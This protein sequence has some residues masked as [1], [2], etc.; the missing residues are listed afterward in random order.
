MWQASKFDVIYRVFTVD[1]IK[2]ST[3]FITVMFS[4]TYFLFFTKTSRHFTQ[5]LTV[6]RQYLFQITYFIEKKSSLTE[7]SRFKRK[8]PFCT[9]ILS[10]LIFFAKSKSVRPSLFSANIATAWMTHCAPI[11]PP[12]TKCVSLQN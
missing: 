10:G 1:A 6:S 3:S 8:F 2:R 4:Q 11:T 7:S 5:I 12:F 9:K